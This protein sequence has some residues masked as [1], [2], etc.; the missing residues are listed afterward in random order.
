MALIKK[1]AG[2]TLIYGS[3]YIISRVLHYLFI[4]AYLTRV[5]SGNPF[6]FGLY[7]ELYFYAALLI[8]ILTLRMET[9]YFRFGSE[10]EEKEHSFSTAFQ[11][12]G[13]TGAVMFITGIFWSAEIAEV[14]SYPDFGHYISVLGGILAFDTWCAIPL[15]RLRQENRVVRFAIIKVAGVILN[16]VLVVMFLTIF[17]ILEDRELT[18]FANWYHRNDPIY[19]VLIANLVASIFIFFL[20]TPSI[21]KIRFRISFV[22]WLKMLK[23]A[24]PLIIVGIAGV[25]NQSSFITLQKYL[26]PSSIVQNIGEGGIYAAA[27]KLAILMNLFT[28]AFNY[29]AEPFFFNQSKQIKAKQIYA[30]VAKAFTLV[31]SLL[32][33]ILVFYLD[34]IQVIIGS[35]Y[36]EDVRQVVPVL[37]LAFLMLGLYYNFSI[38]YKVSDKTL[39][40]AYI[41]LGGVAITLVIN[42]SLIGHYGEI[43]SAWA[44]LSC[45]LFMAVLCWLI[46]KINYP[47]PYEIGKIVLCLS[48]AVLLYGISEWI[49]PYFVSVVWIILVNSGLLFLYLTLI[50]RVEKK[51]LLEI[52]RNEI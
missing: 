18:W 44:A 4:S 11:M 35:T 37:A 42:F 51:F 24:L 29:A 10:P 9:T 17:P 21:L 15:A 3:S 5:F 8:V 50:W 34:L 19:D 30:N 33:L 22:L 49:R 23:Y 20:L 40:G 27:V 39:Y 31:A 48:T 47:V 41:S 28:I 7:T 32:F 2:E 14:L 25:I 43:A 52:L 45:Y 1:L 38:W 16:T 12:L 6:H 13:F 46:G 26:L 36:R